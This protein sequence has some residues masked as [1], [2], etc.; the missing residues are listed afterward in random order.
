MSVFKPKD[1][2][3]ILNGNSSESLE[4]LVGQKV[5]YTETRTELTTTLLG[6]LKDNPVGRFGEIELH[7]GDMYWPIDLDAEWSIVPV[8]IPKYVRA[9]EYSSAPTGTI[10]SSMIESPTLVSKVGE[11]S[12]VVGRLKEKWEDSSFHLT[13][14]VI[15]WGGAQ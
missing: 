7:V 5:L 13:R 9:G 12:W 10:L 14:K 2:A 6:V 15:R 3:H 4:S 11:N 8:D 1:T